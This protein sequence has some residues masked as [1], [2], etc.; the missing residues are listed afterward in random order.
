M[1]IAKVTGSSN[2]ATSGTTIDAP[3]S[4]GTVNVNTGDHIIGVAWLNV[5]TLNLSSVAKQSGTATIGTVSYKTKV[6]NGGVI[7]ITLFYCRVT[8]GG[9][10]QLRATSSGTITSGVCAWEAY[11]GASGFNLPTVSSNTGTGVDVH[12]TLTAQYANSWV[13]HVAGANLASN[14]ALATGTNSGE[15][16]ST[17]EQEA[18]AN[19]TGTGDDG[20]A[21]VGS[22]EANTAANTA[23]TVDMNGAAG[24]AYACDAIE[25][26]SQFTIAAGGGQGSSKSNV[27]SSVVSKS[28]T[29]AAT[30]S[31]TASSVISKTGTESASKSL[32]ASSLVSKTATENIAGVGLVMTNIKPDATGTESISSSRVASSVVQKAG[33]E[34]ISGSQQVLTNY[35]SDATGQGSA[36]M[37]IVSSSAI[38]AL[39]IIGTSVTLIASSVVNPSMGI[40]A[41]S[42]QQSSEQQIHAMQVAG[43]FHRYEIPRWVEE[44]EIVLLL[45]G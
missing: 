2:S 45:E 26:V 15:T 34:S 16:H 28:G 6:T 30:K 40:N 13:I 11:S 31:V 9:T 35:K 17:V 4:T 37:S 12:A 1:A 39:G 21:A 32:V 23:Y 7:G 19:P 36:I 42:S 43:F 41:T 33:T 29:E 25:L 44:D 22:P 10:L 3:A 20:S 14:G 27:A 18:H 38:Q 8:A 24:K 5:S